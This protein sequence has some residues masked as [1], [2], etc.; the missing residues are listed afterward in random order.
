MVHLKAIIMHV[1]NY[2]EADLNSCKEYT[3]TIYLVLGILNV[4]GNAPY[5]NPKFLA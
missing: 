2:I 5:S 4:I 1:V 3:V